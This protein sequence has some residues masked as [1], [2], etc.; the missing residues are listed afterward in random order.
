MTELARWDLLYQDPLFELRILAARGERAGSLPIG[1]ELPGQEMVTAASA[2][3]PDGLLAERLAEAGLEQTFGPAR[4]C[5]LRSAELQE[6]ATVPSAA[7]EGLRSALARALVAMAA[8]WEGQADTEKG[9][10]P[11]VLMD[12]RLRDDIV[13]R[14][15]EALGGHLRSV[16]SLFKGLLTGLATRLASR[17]VQRRRGALTDASYPLAGDV[18]LY[19]ARGQGIRQF[20][21]DRVKAAASPVVL[22]AHSL[23]GIAC[24]DLLVL[25]QLEKVSLLITVGSQSPLLYEIGA[26]VSLAFGETLPDHCRKKENDIDTLRERQD[27]KKL[28]AELAARSAKQK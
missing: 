15:V 18:L 1:T 23:G 9:Q 26:L 22:L 6:A 16:G 14:L 8:T 2:L 19:Q 11:V 24:V 12:G 3:R 28:L 21:C 20:I 17:Y 25:K 13:E 27:F 10:E 7:Q 5:V 4:Y